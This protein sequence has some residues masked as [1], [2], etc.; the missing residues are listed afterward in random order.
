MA[1]CLLEMRRVLK[2]TGSI[3][4]HCDPTANYLLRGVTDAVFGWSNF[5]NEIVW[6]YYNGSNSSHTGFGR[7][8]DT[9]LL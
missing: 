9:I 4:L 7:K 1:V 3:Y 2:P 8:H 5:L 6:W